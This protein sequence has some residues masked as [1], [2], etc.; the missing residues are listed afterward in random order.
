VIAEHLSEDEIADLKEMFKMIDADNSGQITF[1]ELKVGSERVG[2]TLKESEILCTYAGNVDNSGTIDYGEFI[3]ATLHLN[4]IKR[5]DHLF[6]AF[7][8]LDK[9]GS[10]YITQDELQQACEEFGVKDVKLEDMIREV[11]QDNE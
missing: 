11:D 4:K 1:E 8:Y 5:E 10:G 9:D 7:S 2:S 6:A 3:A